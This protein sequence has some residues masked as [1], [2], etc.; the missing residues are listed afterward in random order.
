M[1]SKQL[2]TLMLINKS[3]NLKWQLKLKNFLLTL[4]TWVLWG[5]LIYF[6]IERYHAILFTPV[7][8]SLYLY[9][10]IGIMLSVVGSLM[11]MAITWSYMTVKKKK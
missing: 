4:I 10:V 11:F 5:Y 8:Y 6:I 7:F 3:K 1:S 2:Q 9:Q